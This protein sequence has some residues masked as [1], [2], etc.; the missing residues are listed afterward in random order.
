MIGFAFIFFKGAETD[1][2]QK[3]IIHLDCVGFQKMQ[4]GDHTEKKSM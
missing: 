1:S 3:S 2:M 4:T